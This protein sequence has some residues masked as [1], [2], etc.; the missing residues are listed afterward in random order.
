M[1]INSDINGDG[2]YT[3]PE[4]IKEANKAWKTIEAQLTSRIKTYCNNRDEAMIMIK[5]G[6]PSYQGIIEYG[7]TP[8]IRK[9][10]IRILELAIEAVEA[11]IGKPDNESD[12]QRWIADRKERLGMDTAPLQSK[13]THYAFPDNFM[14]IMAQPAPEGIPN[15]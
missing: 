2:Y 9:G 3:N 11:I 10:G 14:D 15:Y 6:L 4:V 8:E 7:S 1:S 5:E 12:M 13:V